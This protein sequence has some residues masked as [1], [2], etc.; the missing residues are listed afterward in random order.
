MLR[1]VQRASSARRSDS[2]ASS[3]H[4]LN[5][6]GDGPER[7]EQG[8]ETDQNGSCGLRPKGPFWDVPETRR[9]EERLGS[10]PTSDVLPLPSS[11]WSYPLGLGLDFGQSSALSSTLTYS[12]NVRS[13]TIIHRS[14]S[15][16]AAT[17]LSEKIRRRGQRH[18]GFLCEYNTRALS[19]HF[20]FMV[21][22]SADQIVQLPSS[23]YCDQHMASGQER[24]GR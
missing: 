15:S 19:R 16:S 10:G 23:Y 11:T 6:S 13:S 24:R 12:A 17:S 2:K 20:E 5:G 9:C 3:Q 1:D 18:S 14:S 22:E 4:I 7:I 8:V 21:S